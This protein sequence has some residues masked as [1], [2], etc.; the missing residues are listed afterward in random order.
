MHPFLKREDDGA[1]VIRSKRAIAGWRDS[2]IIE[3][4]YCVVDLHVHNQQV[5]LPKIL[6]IGMLAMAFPILHF[7][8]CVKV[9]RQERLTQ[10]TLGEMFFLSTYAM[11]TI[12]LLILSIQVERRKLIQSRGSRCRKSSKPKARASKYTH[13]QPATEKADPAC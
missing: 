4:S 8:V 9:E 1:V 11:I 13:R 7:G 5:Y 2:C 12:G 6:L 10:I 3:P